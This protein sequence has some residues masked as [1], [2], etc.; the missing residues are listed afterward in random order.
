M[1]TYLFQQSFRWFGPNDPVS[2]A[3]IQMAGC[4]HVVTALHEIPNG[5]V[6]PLEMIRDRK[7]EIEQA[8]LKW[9]VVESIPVHEE[10]KKRSGGFEKYVENYKQSMINL[11]EAG[12][13]VITY[14]F[15]PVLDWT[16]TQLAFQLPNGARALR[17]DMIDYI[18][19][20]LFILKRP[21]AQY[22]S[23]E[24]EKAKK[25]FETASDL[26]K[27][28]LTRSILAGLPGS[29][30]TY[31][32]EAFR[33][34]LS[35][36]SDIGPDELRKNLIEFL[37]DIVPVAEENNLLLALHPD[38]PPFPLFGL[39]RVVSRQ[40]DY[41]KLFDAAPSMANGICFCTGSLGAIPE[42]DIL[43]MI[44]AF[45]DRI[46]FVHLRNVK[47]ESDGSF[48]EADHLNGS[49]DMVEVVSML[50]IIMQVRKINLPM[51]P[52]HGHSILDDQVKNTNPGYTAIGRL[53]GLA[54]IRGLEMGLGRFISE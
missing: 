24:S 45:T 37:K 27:D 51:R 54:E 3:D 28:E 43:S 48:Y 17:F 19:F 22:S 26:E 14:N 52:D 33:E 31:T 12:I 25:R 29:E 50:S 36:Y 9:E 1:K 49:T 34:A 8:G 13:K 18:L 10:I 21:E 4:S 2:L 20:D 44:D 30:E 41:Q 15:M 42:N 38:D 39:P 35:A 46:H 6:W 7:D 23:T 40:D 16:R 53:K 32:V 47:R 11:A 5:E